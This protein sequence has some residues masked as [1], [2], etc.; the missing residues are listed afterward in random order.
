MNQKYLASVAFFMTFISYVDGTN[1]KDASFDP[2][3]I[4]AVK[5]YLANECNM[6]TYGA[7]RCGEI[8]TKRVP[9]KNNAVDYVVE[10]DACG[11][12]PVYQETI[13]I[14]GGVLFRQNDTLQGPFPLQSNILGESD[15]PRA[16]GDVNSWN[17]PTPQRVVDYKNMGF[18]IGHRQSVCGHMDL[19]S[20]NK[21]KPH[22]QNDGREWIES[23]NLQTAGPDS[24]KRTIKL[25]RYLL[26]HERNWLLWRSKYYCNTTE[27]WTQTRTKLSEFAERVVTQ[28]TEYQEDVHNMKKYVQPWG[29]AAFVVA[30]YGAT[31]AYSWLSQLLL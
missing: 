5:H 24:E 3:L 30:A 22:W 13:V 1:H 2:L 10:L 17:Q 29:C 23:D 15:Y 11:N 18:A 16:V 8:S 4:A 14:K 21:L 27:T 31:K 12:S 6:Y 20:K 26:Y 7:Y 19:F 9:N 25:K 28:R